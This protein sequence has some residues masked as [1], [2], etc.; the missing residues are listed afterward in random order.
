MA[1]SKV[2]IWFV[3]ARGGVATTTIVGL[4]ALKKGRIGPT[5]LVSE[6]PFF[7]HLDLL[8][9]DSFAVGG[10]DIRSATLVETA[11]E[12]VAQN[13]LSADLVTACRRELTR[14]EKNLK[15]GTLINVG[16]AITDLADTR[17]KRK[18]EKAQE[19]VDRIQADLKEFSKRNKLDQ[20]IVINLASTEPPFDDKS[21]P[22]KWSELKKKLS[23]SKCTLGASSIYAI[24]ALD[25]GH[26]YINFTPSVGSDT[27]AICELAELRE[28]CHM[29]HDGKTGETL[30]KTVLAPMFAH[31]NLAVMSWVGH[32]IFGNLDGKI[33]DDPLNK[34]T[35]VRSKDQAL[36][37]ILGYS[38]Q[39]LVSIE[40]IKSL[41]DW[42]TAWDH[43]HF[44]GFLDT[45]MKLQFTWQGCDSILAA[46]LVLDLARFCHK[47]HQSGERGLL[48]FLSSFFKSP[49]GVREA[50]FA[51]QFQQLLDW[52]RNVDLG[53]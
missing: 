32:N 17:L 53:E 10:H 46:P 29:G 22:R 21:L 7:T 39:S 3:G 41:G 1:K 18:Q 6:L 8:P 47:A 52:A 13:A 51:L 40:Y 2:G 45:P 20:V 16:D 23:S 30:L 42:K 4:W 43:I 35:K 27:P 38:P 25:L 34:E 19:A 14:I 26:P 37:Q 24:A 11:Q 49:Q 44:K 9:W 5:G 12:L 36:A 50:D 31:R 48:T 33:L 28:T 15:P